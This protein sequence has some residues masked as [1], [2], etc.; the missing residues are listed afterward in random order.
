[1]TTGDLC[2]ICSALWVIVHLYPFLKGMLGKQDR[3]PTTT[4]IVVW[5]ILFAS[6]LTH[7]CVRANPF[8]AKGGPV[9]KNC[10]LSCGN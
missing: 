2:L 6:I 9:L 8:V 4:I 3:M 1:M 5:S 10:G 7:L